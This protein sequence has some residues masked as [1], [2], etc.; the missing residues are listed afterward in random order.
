M[1][2]QKQDL[3]KSKADFTEE[4][5][6]HPAKGINDWNDRLDE[7]WN[8]KT[9]TILLLMKRPKIFRLSMAVVTNLTKTTAEY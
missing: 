7:T 4:H 9:I 6:K 1:E 8:P 3:A 5:I 2:N